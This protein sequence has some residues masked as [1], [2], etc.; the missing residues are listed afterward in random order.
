MRVRQILS[1][2]DIVKGLEAARK[3]ISAKFPDLKLNEMS[4]LT[5]SSD[6]DLEPSVSIK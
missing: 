1:L 4:V 5:G 2:K 3:R 6:F